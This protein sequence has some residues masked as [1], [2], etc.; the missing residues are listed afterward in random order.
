[1]IISELELIIIKSIVLFKKDIE[2]IGDHFCY[3]FTYV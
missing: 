3:Y 2:P 1:M